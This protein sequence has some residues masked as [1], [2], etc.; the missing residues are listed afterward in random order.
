MM[1]ALKGLASFSD[2]CKTIKGLCQSAA[3]KRLRG[4]LRPLISLEQ[5]ALCISK[6]SLSTRHCRAGSLRGSEAQA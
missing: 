5:M 3:C 6:L 1:N 4:P 2:G